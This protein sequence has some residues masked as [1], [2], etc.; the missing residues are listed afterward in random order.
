MST[1]RWSYD[2]AADFGLP[3]AE[4]LARVPREPD[5]AVSAAR[6]AAAVV[7]RAALRTVW[8][9]RVEGAERLPRSGSFVLVANHA[10]HLDTAAL[11]SLLPLGAL[12]RAYPLGARDVFAANRA[13]A[14]ASGVA[15][16][17]LPFDRDVPACR[18]F[19]ACRD[20]LAGDGNV[21]IVYPEGTRSTDG[22]VAPFKPGVGH[23]VAGLGV[24]VVP[25][26]VSGTARVWPKGARVPRPGRIGV[27]VGEPRVYERFERAKAAAVA[28][29]D[30]L[31]AAVLD[32]SEGAPYVHDDDHRI[33][34][35]RRLRA[36][37]G[38]LGRH[39]DLLPRVAP[40]R[41]GAARRRPLSPRP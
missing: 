7:V 37:G 8:R 4:R 12:D 18:A 19:D 27:R 33:D 28:I 5:F 26:F 29:A 25:C 10:S 13:V 40:A 11:L 32:L 35:A 3:L 39:A 6:V 30:D 2:T 36:P 22:R 15:F 17:V 20:L 31:R 9:A 23:L 21:L 1:D 41:A 14:I 34:D 24:P 38:A 16:N